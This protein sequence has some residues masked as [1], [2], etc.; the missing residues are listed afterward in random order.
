VRTRPRPSVFRIFDSGIVDVIGHTY[1]TY[2]I[3]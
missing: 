1:D 3:L 2:A